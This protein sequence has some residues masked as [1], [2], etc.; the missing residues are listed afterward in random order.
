MV[1]ERMSDEGLRRLAEA[2]HVRVMADDVVSHALQPR[3]PPRSQRAARRLLGRGTRRTADLLRTL[4]PRNNR[5]APAQRQ[6]TTRRDGRAR[7][8]LLRPSP[9]RRLPHRSAAATGAAR[10]VR[11]GHHNNHCPPTTPPPTTSPKN[12]ASPAGPGTPCFPPGTRCDE[13]PQSLRP[14]GRQRDG[15]RRWATRSP[16]RWQAARAFCSDGRP[17]DAGCAATARATLP[18]ARSGESSDCR[19]G[20]YAPSRRGRDLR[21]QATRP[22]HCRDAAERARQ[23]LLGG[24]RLDEIVVGPRV[25]AGDTVGHGI[26]RRQ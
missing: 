19:A 24:K 14:Q 8:R 3:L 16:P 18:H 5:R 1:P 15:G 23:Q 6:R 25:E 12:W 4:R 7:D 22:A 13:P 21:T 17:T 20:R 11:L 2:W 26:A 10:L 9:R